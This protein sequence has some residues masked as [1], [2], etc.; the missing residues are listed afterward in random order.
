MAFTVWTTPFSVSPSSSTSVTSE[1]A[2]DAG[3]PSVLSRTSFANAVAEV[4]CSRSFRVAVV[5]RTVTS[6]VQS[7]FCLGE[8]STRT[9]DPVSS[10][11]SGTAT[12][13]PS[14]SVH[15]PGPP[16]RFAHVCSVTVSNSSHFRVV[17]P[18]I[19]VRACRVT[20]A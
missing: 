15:A 2:S 7:S 6:Y 1:G 5:V 9:P 16:Y 18:D 14:W 3:T 20:T 17:W 19:L 8:T 11:G 13:V 12:S 4:S 10:H